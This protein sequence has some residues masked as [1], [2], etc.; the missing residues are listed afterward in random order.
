VTDFDFDLLVSSLPAGVDANPH[1]N[2]SP[3][4]LE[5]NQRFEASLQRLQVSRRDIASWNRTA[6]PKSVLF[7]KGKLEG[8][9]HLRTTSEAY[10]FGTTAVVDL[11]HIGMVRLSNVEP[12]PPG[13]GDDQ[14]GLKK[15]LARLLNRRVVAGA[16]A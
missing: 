3:E 15:L 16:A 10:V 6:G 1:Q 11:Q 2:G 8:K 4:H 5:W 9:V 7:C 13:M 12:A 14:G